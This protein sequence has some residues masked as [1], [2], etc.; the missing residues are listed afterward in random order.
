MDQN[1]KNIRSLI[2]ILNEWTSFYDAGKPIVS[3]EKWDNVYFKLEKLEQETGIIYPD[4]PT[5]SINF[6]TL[7]KL[8]KVKHDQPPM[9]SL[10][11]TKDKNDLVSFVKGQDWMAMFKLDGLSCRLVYANGNLIQASTRGNGIVGEDIT[12]NANIIS[13]IPKSIPYL[14][15]LIV[16]G[17]IICDYES[18]KLF[19]NS[20]ANPRN[21]AAGSIRQLSSEEAASRRLSF[22]AWDLIKGYDDID[23]FFHRLEK[24]DDLGFDTVPR[25]GDAETIEDAIEIL[26][27]IR[28]ERPY[29][30]YPIDGYV[31]RFESQAYYNSLG[32]TDHHFRGAIAYKFYDEE[33][34]TELIDIDWT[35]GRSGIL[36]PVAM[37]KPVDT[38]DSIIER[39]SMHNLSI[40]RELLGSKPYKGQKI[41]VVKQNMIIP[42]ILRAEK[43]RE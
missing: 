10:D 6:Q 32:N 23:F 39:A 34:E 31:F 18:F 11:K 24:L 22:V 30:C 1:A 19:E 26:N 2:N 41:W 14:D 28:A 27:N 12:H 37:F 29:G 35:M 16:D 7:S 21:F 15:T 13:N 17:E 9:L 38:G 43:I 20:Y 5:Q 42:Q 36:T 8:E 4:S 3:D 33:Y 40:M 25:V